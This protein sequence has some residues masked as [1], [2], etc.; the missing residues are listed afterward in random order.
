MLYYSLTVRKDLTEEGASERDMSHTVAFVQAVRFRKTH[1]L[2]TD[3]IKD[4]ME[5]PDTKY[6]AIVPEQFTMQTQKE[7]VTL[8]PN[9]GVMILILSAFRRLA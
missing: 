1:R 7:I 2:Y 9:D 8:H 3:L 5:N 4:S 6:F